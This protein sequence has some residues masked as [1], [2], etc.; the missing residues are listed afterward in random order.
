MYLYTEL[1]GQQTPTA[2]PSITGK[3]ENALPK[4]NENYNEQIKLKINS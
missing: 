4:A 2:H 1:L 3:M